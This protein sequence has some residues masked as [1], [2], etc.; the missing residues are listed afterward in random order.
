MAIPQQMVVSGNEN[1]PLT[2][3]NITSAT[4]WWTWA[5]IQ[6]VNSG[7]K[8]NCLTA[9][10]SCSWSAKQPPFLAFQFALGIAEDCFSSSSSR[11]LSLPEFLFY[12]HPCHTIPPNP[13]LHST[14]KS[15]GPEVIF[16]IPLSPPKSDCRAKRW[17][18]SRYTVQTV[19]ERVTN[20]EPGHESSGPDLALSRMDCTSLGKLFSHPG[21]WSPHL[22]EEEAGPDDGE[23]PSSLETLG[24]RN[25]WISTHLSQAFCQQINNG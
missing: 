12:L 7:S 13:G 16:Y 17:A 3:Q 19:L 1:T 5:T 10:V 6:A 24:L 22:Y 8:G 25:W 15:V 9:S 14:V 4:M 18:Q 11:S 2:Q 20:T 21:P 23:G